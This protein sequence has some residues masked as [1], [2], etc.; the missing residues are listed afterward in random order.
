DLGGL[1]AVDAVKTL[2]GSLDSV[3]SNDLYQNL[4]F[5]VKAAD[6]GFT[7]GS[8][9]GGGGGGAPSAPVQPAAPVMEYTGNGP[10]DLDGNGAVQYR[11][12]I[13]TAEKDA[14]LSI[15]QGVRAKDMFGRALESVTL[16]SVPA[17]DLPGVDAGPEAFGR[18]L[19]GGPDGATFDPAVEVSLTLTPEEW[20]RLAAGEQFVVRWYNSK[21]GTWESLETTVDS[22]K[23][24]VTA[25]VSHF[26]LFAVF[27]EAKPAA[28]PE[29]TATVPIAAPTTEA[30][31]TA[32]STPAPQGVGVGF[33]W[34]WAAGG[35]V[36]LV[37]FGGIYAFRKK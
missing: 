5:V 2:T 4:S 14:A 12:V 20:E 34:Q 11:T 37:L 10:L 22:M 13:S 32:A 30:V 28:A 18:A 36:L 9:G 19:K 25:K 16:R 15:G 29:A 24:S 26:T 3:D 27:A 1:S 17:D 23:R 33:P 35:G 21:T 31:E 8:S 6:S 7:G